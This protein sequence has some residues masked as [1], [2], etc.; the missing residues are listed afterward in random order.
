MGYGCVSGRARGYFGGD[1]R[2]A[3]GRE[4]GFVDG[5]LDIEIEDRGRLYPIDGCDAC[6]LGKGTGVTG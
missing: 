2:H 4:F 5:E 3:I 6:Y 1:L